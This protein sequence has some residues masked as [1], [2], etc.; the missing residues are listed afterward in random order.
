[1]NPVK[2]VYAYVVR[3]VEGEPQILTLQPLE[4]LSDLRVPRR[5]L[6]NQED[7]YSSVLQ[8]VKDQTGI[9]EFEDM[10]FVTD[11]LWK[12]EDGNLYH[13]FFYRLV[14]ADESG[15]VSDSDD[16]HMQWI[17]REEQVPFQEGYGDYISRVF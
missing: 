4:N 14:T 11:D 8:E 5:I 13:R 9:E 15:E 2:K 10:T 16:F 1:M 3:Y 17:S 6:K 7:T 12:S